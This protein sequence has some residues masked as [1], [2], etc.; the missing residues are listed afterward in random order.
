MP[1]KEAKLSTF[2]RKKKKTTKTLKK[3][4]KQTSF[5]LFKHL[6]PAQKR[7]GTAQQI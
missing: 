5:Q 3:N 7:R 4:K 1:F 2:E 6:P